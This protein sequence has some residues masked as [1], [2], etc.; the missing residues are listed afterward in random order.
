[1]HD[2]ES[3]F[4]P[5]ATD[6]EAATGPA[7]DRAAAERDEA[8]EWVRQQFSKAST[9]GGTP[10]ERYLSEHRGLRGP[11]PAA[12]RWRPDYRIKPDATPRPCLLAAVINPAGDIVG[13]HSIEIDPPT[14]MKSRRTATPKLSRGPISEGSV[15]LGNLQEPAATLVIGEGL[16]TTLTRSLIGPCDPHACLGALRFI[17]PR[18]Q[19][20]R[21]EILADTDKR[22]AARRS[23][24][25]SPKGTL[26]VR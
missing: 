19:H 11:W 21:V 9:I 4:S 23:S 13:L 2:A 24:A 15:S 1:M 17:E 12:L 18:P 10:A 5:I 3:M 25:R 8:I 6:E 22:D 7:V 26:L 14:G 16:E 20:T